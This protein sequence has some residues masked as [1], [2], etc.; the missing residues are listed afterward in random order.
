[1]EGFEARQVV[2]LLLLSK[3]RILDTLCVL[4]TRRSTLHSDT[5]EMERYEIGGSGKVSYLVVSYL[6]SYRVV[7]YLDRTLL[8]SDKGSGESY[9]VQVDLS[10][11]RRY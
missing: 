4:D 5:M 9:L 7:S 3:A 2:G 11:S 10:I 8:H 6:V 1:M